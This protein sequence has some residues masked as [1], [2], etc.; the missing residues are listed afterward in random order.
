MV[1]TPQLCP[2]RG[3]H[4]GVP[5]GGKTSIFVFLLDFQNAQTPL[6]FKI[7]IFAFLF[8]MIKTGTGPVLPRPWWHCSN[9]HIYEQVIKRVILT[10]SIQECPPPDS[11]LSRN[12][13]PTCGQSWSRCSLEMCRTST[14]PGLYLWICIFS[15]KFVCIWVLVVS[16]QDVPRVDKIDVLYKCFY[17]VKVKLNPSGWSLWWWKRKEPPLLFLLPPWPPCASTYIRCTDL[18]GWELLRW[19]F[20]KNLP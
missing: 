7:M 13:T 6:I 2:R 11:T 3:L 15:R 17:D 16:F 10:T 12:Y 18:P 19:L 20:S 5:Q 8:D 14:S 9:L 4:W 1:L